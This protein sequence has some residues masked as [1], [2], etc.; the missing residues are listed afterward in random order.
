MTQAQTQSE[1]TLGQAQGP[2]AALQSLGIDAASVSLCPAAILGPSLRV[3][4]ETDLCLRGRVGAGGTCGGE[5][6]AA[7]AVATRHLRL[8]AAV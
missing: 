2:S 6:G 8:S 3:L 5:G 7:G 4:A 1:S